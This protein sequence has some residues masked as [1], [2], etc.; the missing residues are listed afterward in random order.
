MSGVVDLQALERNLVHS[1]LYEWVTTRSPRNY[2]VNP[3]LNL[4]TLY[5]QKPLLFVYFNRPVGRIESIRSDDCGWYHSFQYP[6]YLR[7]CLDYQVRCLLSTPA[8]NGDWIVE[9]PLW[10][11][12]V[13]SEE[14]AQFGVLRLQ[15]KYKDSPMGGGLAISTTSI[16][17]PLSA[18]D[19]AKVKFLFDD[20]SSF[21]S[22]KGSQKAHARHLTKYI[23]QGLKIGNSPFHPPIGGAYGSDK[24]SKR[25]PLSTQTVSGISKSLRPI[26]RIIDNVYKDIRGGVPGDYDISTT[27]DSG[28]SLI[29]SRH[30]ESQVKRHGSI[31]HRPPN[32]SFFMQIRAPSI[33]E[34]DESHGKTEKGYRIVP[35]VTEA[36]LK[37]M[38]A[39][40][41]HHYKRGYIKSEDLM[42][43]LVKLG[44]EEL[45]G[46]ED[47]DGRLET[48]TGII[49]LLQEATDISEFVGDKYY[50]SFTYPAFS[51]GL[52]SLVPCDPCSRCDVF[53]NGPEYLSEPNGLDTAF[54][55]PIY[56]SRF[57][58]VVVVSKTRI[59]LKRNSPSTFETFE[60]NYIF[61]QG[62]IKQRIERRIRSDMLRAYLLAVEDAIVDSACSGIDPETGL[63][64]VSKAEFDWVALDGRK[65]DSSDSPEEVR[66]E[67]NVEL[68]RFWWKR[69]NN[70]LRKLAELMPFAQITILEDSGRFDSHHKLK[71]LVLVEHRYYVSLRQN[72]Y[73]TRKVLVSDTDHLRDSD[74][75]DLLNRVELRLRLQWTLLAE[76]SLTDE[77][78]H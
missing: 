66:S 28:A 54:V 18:D 69:A 47:L 5:I 13:A 21:D 41:S 75:D 12:R 72:P 67:L 53:C 27:V 3:L 60:Y 37:D 55:V 6:Q 52:A 39:L 42:D 61:M 24:H 14:F 73:Y 25:L 16:A 46:S 17:E 63:E 65:I 68:D 31:E 36:M 35:I 40:F 70:A 78:A 50:H 74:I 49:E 48:S 30:R 44:V 43:Y 76:T 62:I 15:L 20:I 51:S 23:Y 32:L 34:H 77:Q 22:W 19:F 57:V 59:D 1:A 33:R 56:V 58:S 64:S 9:P 8:K 29:W 38:A 2:G 10:G 11:G 7:E 4:L 26:C 71:T 45:P